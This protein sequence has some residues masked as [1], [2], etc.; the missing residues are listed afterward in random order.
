VA[1]T[2]TYASQTLTIP[3]T[4]SAG[5]TTN[6]YDA[7]TSPVIDCRKQ[8]SVAV[9]FTFA[10]ANTGTNNVQILTWCR[11]VDGTKYD[12]N[13]MFT[14]AVAALTAGTTPVT[15]VTNLSSLNAGYIKLYSWQNA[16]TNV[17]GAALS[18]AVKISSP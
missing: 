10:L 14:T 16:E 9:A 11:S 15:L 6:F 17:T 2:P 1:Q 12:T 8:A 7:G 18:Y 3:T 5:S 13:R 4:L